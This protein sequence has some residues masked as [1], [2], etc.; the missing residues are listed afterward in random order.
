MPIFKIEVRM[1]Q[2][3]YSAILVEAENI[4]KAL[5]Y[6][7]KNNEWYDDACDGDNTRLTAKALN[8][9][10]VK[11]LEDFELIDPSCL[12]WNGDRIHSIHE[13]LQATKDAKQQGCFFDQI[14]RARTE[15]QAK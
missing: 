12:P 3:H 8:G 6:T 13:I 7:Q 1:R 4:E 10:E 15:N 14:E 11:E 2:E 9:R 5:A